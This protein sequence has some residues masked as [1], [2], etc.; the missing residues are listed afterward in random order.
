MLE[1]QVATRPRALLSRVLL[2]S[3]P[4]RA[5]NSSTALQWQFTSY[6]YG[7][8]E[9][10]PNR[11]CYK[12]SHVHNAECVVHTVALLQSMLERQVATRPRALLSRVLLQ[13]KPWSTR[14]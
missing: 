4:R 8:Q 1:R 5:L 2:Q 3:K 13:S 9:G 14:T 12:A 11:D 10:T 7:S 6:G